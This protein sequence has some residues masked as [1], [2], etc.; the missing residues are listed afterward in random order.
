MHGLIFSGFTAAPYTGK[1]IYKRTVGAHR[2]AHYLRERGWDIE[3]LD[4]VVG[5][6]LDELKEYSR[7]RVNSKTKWIGFGG[8]FPV[9]NDTLETF[10]VWFKETY[11]TIP[12]VA[13]GQISN[14]Y[15]IKA[16]WYVDGFG[17]RAIEA[18]L[19]HLFGNPTEPLKYQLFTNGR[20]IVKGNLDYPSFPMK[21]LKVKY[22]DRDFIMPEE[23][24]VT[25]FGRGCIF[26][27]NFCNF[28]IL[29]IKEDHSRDADD[30]YEELQDTYDRFGVTRYTIADETV[31]DYTE[32]LAKFAGA[33]KRMNFQPSFAGFARADL[34][35]SRPQDWDIMLEMGFTAHH[36]GIES[37]NP[38]SLKVIGKGMHPDKLLPKLLDARSYFRKHGTYKGQVSLIAGLPYE[39]RDSL[40]NTLKWFRENWSTENTLLFPLYI[41]KAGSGDSESKLTSDWQ[42]WGYRETATDMY[43]VIRDKY[44][45]ILT[46]YGTGAALIDHTGVSWENDEWDIMD[47]HKIVHDFYVP[48]YYNQ[49]NGTVIWGMGEWEWI[50]KKP[51]N[52]FLD[53]T[54]NQ[55]M[56]GY[57]EG[58]GWIYIRDHHHLLVRDYVAKK[59]NY[60]PT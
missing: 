46:Q 53:K 4:F 32:K 25:E 41:P 2:I 5:W 12:I 19:E 14:L 44:N 40:N 54:I 15:K 60:V 51:R 17:E 29:G 35:V 21:S 56:Q 20:K 9:W 47:V 24:L 37:T 22:E 28:P 18:L 43:T 48:E 49:Y 31:N 38:E 39:T 34:F 6:T 42:K 1:A 33:V 23:T 13:G 11:P 36:Y 59:L 3:V 10:F 57:T 7:S 52:Y 55:I 27:C 45:Y 50:L 16:D 8:T 26:K 30:F 58:N